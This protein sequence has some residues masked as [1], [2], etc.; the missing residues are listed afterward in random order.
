MSNL[1]LFDNDAVPQPKDKVKLVEITVTPYPEGNRVRLVIRITPFQERP[2]I[3]IYARKK[4]GPIVAE[5]SVIET[6]TPNLDFTLHIRGID[7][8]TGDYIVRAELYYE[9]RNEPQHVRE[10]SFSIAQ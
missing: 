9:D 4:D 7:S 10:V 8:L 1:F 3:E 2:N 5:M 6:M